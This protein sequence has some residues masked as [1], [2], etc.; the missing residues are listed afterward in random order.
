MTTGTPLA[1]SVSDWHLLRFLSACFGEILA[2][3]LPHCPCCCRNDFSLLASR[4]CQHAQPCRDEWP[5][6]VLTAW[7]EACPTN[8]VSNDVIFPL[9][10]E[11]G[12]VNMILY[13][14]AVNKIEWLMETNS[15]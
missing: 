7:Q 4:L 15:L 13:I 14:D 3:P 5:R 9:D 2:V 11:D 1:V 10:L 8:G 12:F 6:A